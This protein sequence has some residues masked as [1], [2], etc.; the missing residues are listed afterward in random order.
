[1]LE[2]AEYHV[3]W[4]QTNNEPS[5]DRRQKKGSCVETAMKRQPWDQP[6]VSLHGRCPVTAGTFLVKL[7]CTSRL[8]DLRS[9]LL[10]D[11]LSWPIGV[12]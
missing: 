11:V 2:T 7:V 5:I 9:P 3:A 10:G 6:K 4:F 12:T 1:M 8:R